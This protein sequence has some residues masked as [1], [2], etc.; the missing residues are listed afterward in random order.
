ME[1]KTAR[2]RSTRTK[3]K[4]F[5]TSHFLYF[6]LRSLFP[7]HKEFDYRWEWNP[8]TYA[9]KLAALEETGK[10]RSKHK[11]NYP[12]PLIVI[13]YSWVGSFVGIAVAAIV[14]QYGFSHLDKPLLIGSFG[15]TAV[16]IYGA[17]QSPLAQPK[18]VLGGHGIAALVG[19][20]C[21][22][23]MGS[24]WYSCALA[25]SLAIAFMLLTTTPH[26]PAGATALIAV[27]GGDTVYDAGYYY[28]LTTL[29]G[30]SIMLGVALLWN[31]LPRAPHMKYPRYWL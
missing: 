17:Q 23:A 25:V 28:V 15:A 3:A 11:Q 2:S 16:L 13:F 21:Y 19:V 14:T 26:P 27:T 10:N 18:N 1:H 4:A 9:K 22:K 30:V 12:L 29:F 6:Y 7:T 24:E 5:L 20:T 8:W 31:N